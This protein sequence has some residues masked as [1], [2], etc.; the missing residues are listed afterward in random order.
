MLKTRTPRQN[1]KTRADKMKSVKS[2]HEV[3]L[4]AN[5]GLVLDVLVSAVNVKVSVNIQYK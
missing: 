5:V 2:M 3:V 1:V 4:N